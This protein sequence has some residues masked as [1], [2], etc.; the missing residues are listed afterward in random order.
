MKE[1]YKKPQIISSDKISGAI[2]AA[3]LAAL[4]AAV[5]FGTGFTSGSNVRRALGNVINWNRGRSLVE[6]GASV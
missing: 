1:E 4:G 6:G 3:A 2:P 5:A